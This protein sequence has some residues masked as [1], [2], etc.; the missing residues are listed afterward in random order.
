MLNF[1]QLT[2]NLIKKSDSRSYGSLS[3]HLIRL[4]DDLKWSIFSKLKKNFECVR[5]NILRLV[6]VDRI[7][8]TVGYSGSFKEV[9]LVSFV[10]KSYLFLAMEDT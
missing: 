1:T 5:N 8:L 6:Y 10:S 2:K 4:G 7:I 9:I 3:V